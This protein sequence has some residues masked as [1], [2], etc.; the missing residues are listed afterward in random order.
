MSVFTRINEAR[1][2]AFFRQNAIF[3]IGSM[4]VAFLNYLY[5][6]I[7]GRLLSN[8]SF[9]ELQ[10]IVSSFMQL[11]IILNVLS[12]V[13]INIYV[14]ERNKK[15]ALATVAEL[16]K[17]SFWIGLVLLAGIAVAAEP[18]KQA[19]QFESALPFIAIVVAFILTVPLTFRNAYLKA[20]KD[21]NAAS[22]VGL[23][24]STAKLLVSVALVYIALK[25]LGAVLGIVLSQLVA[26]T[27]ANYRAHKSGYHKNDTAFIKRKPNLKILKPQIPYAMF[28]L[29]VSLLTT[30]QITVDVTLVKYYFTPEEAGSYAAIA[31]VARIIFFLAGSII[32]VM[33]SSIGSSKTS[34]ENTSMLIR[35]F[36]LVTLI[37]GSA[38]LVFC[39]MPTFV[40]HL[41]LGT[42][43]DDLSYL[44]PMLSIAIFTGSLVSLFSTYFIALRKYYSMIFIA[45]GSILTFLIIVMTTK[46]I[47]HIVLGLL[48]GSVTTLLGLVVYAW[49][50]H[51][52]TIRGGN[53]EKA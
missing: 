19:L 25:T 38:T 4:A 48:I 40:I 11:T 32:A 5:Y 39:F 47:G 16:E 8:V 20:Q 12:L 31:T 44:L 9:G 46:T 14:N 7:L 27:Y 35:S 43:Y 15:V 49:L 18:L 29:V 41:L 52:Q 13:S 10:V 37:S 33:L 6:P 23:L 30:L 51:Y 50:V 1:G 42:R 34:K 2:S 24:G 45:S 28:V 17:I 53:F 22:L 21:F 3:F 26:L 36:G